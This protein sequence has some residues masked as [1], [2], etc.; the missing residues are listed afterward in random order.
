MQKSKCKSEEQGIL[1]VPS[2]RPLEAAA[3]RSAVLP[4][5]PRLFLTVAF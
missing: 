5:R 4:S 1:P 2:L 3:D